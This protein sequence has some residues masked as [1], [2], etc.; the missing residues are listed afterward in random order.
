[1]TKKLVCA[2]ALATTMFA[3]A[4]ASAGRLQL[5]TL[6]CTIDGGTGYIVTSNKGV[7]CVFRPYHHG[8]AEIYTGVISK[9]GVDVGRTHQGQLAWAVFA[10]TRDR[11]A[12][13]LAGSYYG[14]NAEASVVTGGGANLLVGGFDSAF[15]LEPLSVQ[16]QT[17]VNLAVAV[18]SLE[19][20]HSLK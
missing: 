9:L 11:D 16:A 13:D 19:L 8:P 5:G 15:M 2:A 14:V 10:A 18:T 12:G 4:P 17:G 6:D 1:M 20:I 3:V 7:S